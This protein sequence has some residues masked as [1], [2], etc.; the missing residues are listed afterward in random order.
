[1]T[2]PAGLARPGIRS[3][4]PILHHPRELR[5]R[6]AAWLGCHGIPDRCLA[7][8][9]WRSPIC[10]RC[11]GLIA[12]YPAAVVALFA[13][14]P[15]TAARA[16]TGALLLLPAAIDGGLQALSS[17]RSTT[18]RRL[19]T[20]M[21]AGLGQLELIGGLTIALLSRVPRVSGGWSGS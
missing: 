14:G 2:T 17:Y 18:A 15:P 12:G 10:A 13:F 20:G 5:S 1:L 7:I 11:L 9:A 8:G 21:L 6:P 16:L 4:P 3:R 19:I